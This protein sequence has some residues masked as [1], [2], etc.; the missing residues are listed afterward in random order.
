MGFGG[1][2]RL[3]PGPPKVQIGGHPPRGRFGAGGGRHQKRALAKRGFWRVAPSPRPALDLVPKTGSSPG[4]ERYTKQYIIRAE[5]AATANLA[6]RGG[7][8]INK[9]DREQFAQK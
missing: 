9:G 3:A 4:K 6:L 1:N 5:T 7:G 2:W 8:L